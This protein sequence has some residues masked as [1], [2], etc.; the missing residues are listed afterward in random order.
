MKEKVP[1][2]LGGY[3]SSFAA[4]Y[5][6]QMIVCTRFI[7]L[8]IPFE[9]DYEISRGCSGHILSMQRYSSDRKELLESSDSTNTVPLDPFD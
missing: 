9:A 4:A 8:V 2:L 3:Q 1:F 7:A 6:R 5:L